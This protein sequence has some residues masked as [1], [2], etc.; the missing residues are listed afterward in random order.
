MSEGDRDPTGRS[1]KHKDPQW[2]RAVTGN[3][4]FG[5]VAER[6]E[7]AASRGVGVGG[8]GCGFYFLTQAALGR[9]DFMGVVQK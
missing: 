2:V 1:Q 8:E 9:K 6:D 3:G 7:A 5:W 4:I